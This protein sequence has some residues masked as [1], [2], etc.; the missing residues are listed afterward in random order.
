MEDPTVTIGEKQNLI[1]NINAQGTEIAENVYRQVGGKKA[2]N[3][4]FAGELAAIGNDKASTLALQGRNADVTLEADYKVELQQK[5]KGVFNNFTAE[6]YN[7]NLQ[8]L[9]DYT[10]GLIITGQDVDAADVL[11]N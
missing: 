9:K 11:E 4:A 10:K 5:L 2:Y 8:G 7:Q 3:F 1:A 6:F